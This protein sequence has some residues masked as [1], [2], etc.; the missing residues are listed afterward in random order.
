MPRLIAWVLFWGAAVVVVATQVL[1]TPAGFVIFGLALAMLF[2]LIN[3]ISLGITDQN[4][5]SSAFVISVLLMS[6]L[7]LKDPLVGL[8]AASILLISTAVGCDMQQDR[9]TGWRLGSNRLLQFRYQVIGICMGAILCVGLTKVF[10]AAYPVLSVNLFD[11]PEARQGQWSAAMTYKLVGALKDLGNLSEYKVKAMLIG[12]G[13]GFV[14]EVLRKVVRANPR[15]Q[16]YVRSSRTGFAVGWTVE[17]VVLASPYASSFGGFVDLPVALW[18]GAGGVMT[19]V[20]NTLGARGTPAHASPTEDHVS[21]E[22][23]GDSLKAD[24]KKETDTELPADMSTTSLLG[25][26]LIAGE[27]LYFLIVGIIGL[28]ALLG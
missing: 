17:S 20:W 25:G 14:I 5:V 9:S 2:V 27:S 8:M 11:N 10:M 18:F 4:P 13:I 23:K 1:N 16:R 26:G 7:G 24:A 21:A 3:G 12:L 28:L 22:V 6:L 19:S 15:Y